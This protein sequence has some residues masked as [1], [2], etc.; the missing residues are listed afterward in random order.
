MHVQEK[1]HVYLVVN[2]GDAVHLGQVLGVYTT[3]QI[4]DDVARKH[5]IKQL[6]DAEENSGYIAVLKKSIEGPSVK[7]KTIIEPLAHRPGLLAVLK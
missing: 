2:M 4:A 6:F 7:T 1:A 5:K 3:R